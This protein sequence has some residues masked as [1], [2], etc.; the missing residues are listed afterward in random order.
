MNTI[1]S[2]DEFKKSITSIK[3]RRKPDTGKRYETVFIEFR[4]LSHIKLEK[5]QFAKRFNII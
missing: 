3:L 1:K 2:Y 5:I 4:V